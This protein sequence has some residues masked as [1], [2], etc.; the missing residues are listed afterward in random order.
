M[1]TEVMIDT[2]SVDV[3]LVESH[4]DGPVSMLCTN[5]KVLG[6]ATDIKDNK[7][8][9][10]NIHNLLDK[11][12]EICI[13]NLSKMYESRPPVFL[14]V[15]TDKCFVAKTSIMYYKKERFQKISIFKKDSIRSTHAQLSELK[16][17]MYQRCLWRIHFGP[18]TYLCLLDELFNDT[19]E[20]TE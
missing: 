18:T 2:N 17:S 15:L 4:V 13:C 11:I 20:E 1:S 3:I 10:R 12:T 19:D 6:T 14:K 16:T 9:K 8:C 5:H 7:H